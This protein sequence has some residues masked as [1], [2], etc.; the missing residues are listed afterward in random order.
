MAKSL[1]RGVLA[2]TLGAVAVC[3]AAEPFVKDLSLSEPVKVG[4]TEIG[5]GTYRVTVEGDAVSIAKADTVLAR[6]TGRWEPRSTKSSTNSYVLD[7]RD[8]QLREIRFGGD[9]RALVLIVP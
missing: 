6:T 1:G 7:R 9:A 3:A 4:A 5:A 8:G 2:L